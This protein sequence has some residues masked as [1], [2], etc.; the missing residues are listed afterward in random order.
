MQMAD[1]V[2]GGFRGRWLMRFWRV[3]GQIADEV[4]EGSGAD[5]RQGSGGLRGRKLM[6]FQRVPVRC[7]WLMRF[8]KF[9]GRWLMRFPRV[10]GQIAKNSPRFSKLLGITHE[11]ISVR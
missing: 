3:P 4:P 8:R 5:S 6:K 10:P 1:E 7:R 2:S 9:R 11:F